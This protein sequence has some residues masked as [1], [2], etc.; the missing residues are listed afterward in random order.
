M[1]VRVAIGQLQKLDAE[2]VDFAHQMGV[3]SIQFN[4]RPTPE[5]KG[6]WDVDDVVAYRRACEEAGLVLEAIEN[7]PFGFVDKN[8][9]RSARS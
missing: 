4:L 3:S 5:G 9:Q 2:I 1:T 6:Y 7:V 8:P